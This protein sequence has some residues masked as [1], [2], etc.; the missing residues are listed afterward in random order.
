MAAKH[1]SLPLKLPFGVLL[2]LLPMLLS[3]CSSCPA[4]GSVSSLV[5]IS[6]PFV[7]GF[8][9]TG[10]GTFVPFCAASVS[11]PAFGGEETSWFLC[12]AAFV[13]ATG[14]ASITTLLLLAK[15]K[16]AVLEG[17]LQRSDGD[18]GECRLRRELG[19]P[20]L[21][22]AVRRRI[23]SCRFIDGDTEAA[24]GDLI[25]RVETEDDDTGGTTRGSDLGAGG[26]DAA[27]AGG[28][29][30]DG[31]L[32]IRDF[33]IGFWGASAV[34]DEAG[35]FF[36]ILT[37]VPGSSCTCGAS[38]LLLTDGGSAVCR[39][40]GGTKGVDSS[41]MTVAGVPCEAWPSVL[42]GLDS[43]FTLERSVTGGGITMFA[44][45]DEVFSLGGGV[46]GL[47]RKLFSDGAEMENFGT[48]GPSVVASSGWWGSSMGGG[49]GIL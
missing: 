14:L 39:R 36:L 28:E 24:G 43:C 13:S 30:G 37:S 31:K 4:V 27:T 8:F 10:G 48:V 23:A 46:S 7:L 44:G 32:M 33:L 15:I 2:K 21:L 19:T 49:G 3:C 34:E 16:L 38:E 29:A 1:Q 47:G 41:F 35:M 25:V 45:A 11:P 26:C 40:E 17:D 9:A 20:K 6:F 42:A 22:A 12:V 5:S 18:V